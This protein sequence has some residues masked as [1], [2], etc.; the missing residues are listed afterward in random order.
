MVVDSK[1]K[2]KDK[3]QD[4]QRGRTTREDQHMVQVVKNDGLQKDLA[5]FV[6]L[7]QDVSFLLVSS[8][9]LS[10]IRKYDI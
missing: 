8:Y 7:E 4:H 6:T 9:V 10:Q 1:N 5:V 2:V 3:G